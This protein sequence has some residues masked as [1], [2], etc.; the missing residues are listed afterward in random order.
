MPVD[1]SPGL[2]KQEITVADS[3]AAIKVTLWEANVDS[4]EEDTSYELKNFTVRIYK[5]DKNLSIP[6][7]GAHIIE[8]VDIGTVAQDDLPDDTTTVSNVKIQGARMTS[9][10]SC[11]ACNSKVVPTPQVNAQS[12]N[13]QPVFF[14]HSI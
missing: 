11:V 1:V 5:H 6:K 7:E 3:T 9:Y 2:K 10:V 13:W 8:I 12:F 4:V 14:P